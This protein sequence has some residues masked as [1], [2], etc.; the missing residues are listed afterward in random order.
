MSKT[1]VVANTP[2]GGKTV[3][4]NCFE[5]HAKCGVLAH[6]DADGKLVAVEGN[7]ED[8][9][10]QGRLCMKGRSA[11][12]ILYHE[13]RLNYPMKR[14]GERGEGKWER[15]S[16]D[17]AMNTIYNKIMGYKKEFGARSVAFG[18][19]TGRG[20]NQWELRLQNAFGMTHWIAPV[21]TCLTPIV[22]VSAVTLG[23]C[24]WYP[25][26]R[27]DEANA[28]VL[29]GCN[30]P[31][32]HATY[33]T[34][35]I[36]RGRDRGMKM[37]I[38]DPNYGHPLASKADVFVPV[39][40]GS[41]GILAMSMI[42]HVIENKL[43]DEPFVKNWTNLP[44]LLDPKTLK[45]IMEAQIVEGGLP[46]RYT[47][48]DAK[49]QTVRGLNIPEDEETLLFDG[50]P[51]LYGVHEVTLLDGTVVEVTTAF[52][53]LRARAAKF[54]AKDAA[55]KCWVP[56]ETIVAGA[57][58]YATNQ[59]VCTQIFQGLEEHTNNKE[60]MHAIIALIALTG[61]IFR[62]GTNTR[63]IWNPFSGKLMAGPMAGEISDYSKKNRLGGDAL[64]KYSNP[65]A[66]FKAA[67][68]G[69]PYPV[70]AF[71]TIQGNPI[72]WCENP[73]QTIE[74]LKSLDFVVT[75]DYFLSPTAQLSDIVLPAAHWT[76]RDGIA[77]ESVGS[78]VFAMNKAVEP[79][80]ERRSDNWFFMTL[81][82]MIDPEVWPWT[83]E[84]EFLDY[85][86]RVCETTWEDLSNNWMLAYKDTGDEA[87]LH[88]D[89]SGKCGMSTFSRKIEIYS[90]VMA[91]AGTDPLPDG[92]EPF[93]SPYSSPELAKRYPFVLTS[94]RRYPGYYHSTYRN[95]GHIRDQFRD[96]Y[97]DINERTARDLGIEQGDW[98]AIE[99]QSGSIEMRAN[100]TQGINPSVVSLPHGWNSQPCRELG[101]NEFA[102][103]KKH[104][105]DVN[106][107]WNADERKKKE[108]AWVKNNANALISD[109]YYSSLATP[110]MRSSLCNVTFLRKGE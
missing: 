102:G 27:Y 37:M 61:N 99:S 44:M 66:F 57:E 89:A 63:D 72:S 109:K 40:P 76:E 64:Y 98:C 62:K 30:S 83:S 110:G 50:D 58:F 78:Y 21:H 5:C 54:P 39:R 82:H 36:S 56:C 22:T 73:K 3:R 26:T 101:I 38:I 7:P 23:A 47:V 105:W 14:V 12:Q 17:E 65:T 11:V 16:W 77:D 91:M 74:A 9:R 8:P 2:P 107:T 15:I 33:A 35:P 70:K 4:T 10:S 43:Y 24:P 94:G 97:F 52:E 106:A 48:F 68:T 81:G 13:D 41:D 90:T 45:P 84:E 51:E 1:V 59:P 53:V 96:P 18:Q 42:N 80:Y 71:I 75:M 31:W 103:Q 87:Y 32:S 49:S 100:L 69:E 28:M 86:C 34:G 55:Q 25:T 95:I 46:T 6:V 108:E 104:G 88:P 85:E 92:I 29:W 67:I 19:G 20:T 93:E 79:L 60:S